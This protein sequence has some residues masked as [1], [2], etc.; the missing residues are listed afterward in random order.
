MVQPPPNK[1]ALIEND[2]L[3]IPPS[4]ASP[5]TLPKPD[6]FLEPLLKPK[7]EPIEQHDE[8]NTSH[9]GKDNDIIHK[10]IIY[11]FNPFLIDFK[12]WKIF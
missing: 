2:N 3:Q 9:S 7:L 1:K 6:N 4:A 11:K 5:L 8:E 12:I 10:G